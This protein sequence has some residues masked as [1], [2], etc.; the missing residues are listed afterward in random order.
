MLIKRGDG[1]INHIYTE[2][3]PELNIDEE[4]V[5]KAVKE[6]KNTPLNINNKNT[7]TPEK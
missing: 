1:K 3:N 4:N 2:E 5:R 7:A 6:A